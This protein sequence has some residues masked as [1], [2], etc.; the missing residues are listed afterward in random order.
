MSLTTENEIPELPSEEKKLGGIYVGP[1][2]IRE[3][4]IFSFWDGFLFSAIIALNETFGIAAALSLKAT[5]MAIALMNCLPILLG[6]LGQFF[7]PILSK[8]KKHPKY[9]VLHGARAQSCFL[10]LA[11]FTGWLPERYAVWLFILT[12]VIA[13]IAGNLTNGPWM[14]WMAGLVDDGVRGRHFAWRNRFF[15]WIQFCFSL[16][17]GII[18]RHYNSGNAPWLLFAGIFVLGGMI[19]FVSFQLLKKQYAPAHTP[20]P[21]DLRRFKPHPDFMRYAIAAALFQGLAAMTGPFFNV[22]FLR[23][24]QFNYLYFSMAQAGVVLGT[25]IS[26]SMWGKI[27]DTYGSRRVIQISAFMAC[28]IPL[29][30]LFFHQAIAIWIISLYSG[31]AWGGYNVASLHYIMSAS[32]HAERNAYI[33]FSAALTGIGVFVFSLIGGYLAT[34]IPEI[35]TWRLQSLFLF[36][37]ILR[38]LVFACFFLKLKDFGKRHIALVH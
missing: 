37:G 9:Y 18:A 32:D 8:W 16:G 31:A 25:L 5:A 6:T 34:H 23:D 21:F 24:L 7:L 13:G 15:A 27:S 28:L 33:T 12:F 11:G 22:W 2:K 29:N 10:F 19:R 4:L 30:F 38:L 14:V 3:A 17:S 36:S 1:P 26:L 20:Q 35:F